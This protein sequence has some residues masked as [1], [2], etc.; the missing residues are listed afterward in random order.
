MLLIWKINNALYKCVHIERSK[1][2]NFFPPKNSIQYFSL[3]SKKKMDNCLCVMISLYFRLLRWTIKKKIQITY[4]AFQWPIKNFQFLCWWTPHK[5]L[6]I[7]YW[8]IATVPT[9][10]IFHW[11]QGAY[12]ESDSWIP[13]FLFSVMKRNTSSEMGLGIGESGGWGQLLSTLGSGSRTS[14]ASELK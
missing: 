3:E 13:I 2:L 12:M 8:I 10:I 4:L 9:E 7:F 5:N 1:I 14:T 11:I 6:W